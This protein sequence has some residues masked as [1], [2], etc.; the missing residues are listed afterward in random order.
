[1]GDVTGFLQANDAYFLFGL[2]ILS[3]L[4]LVSTIVLAG[5]VA[6]LSRRRS[7]KIE[8]GRLSD[9]VEHLENNANAISEIQARLED[10]R[11][12]MCEQ[13]KA[14]ECCLQKVGIV[15]FNAFNDV[16]GEQSFAVVLLDSQANGIALSGLYGRQD[17]RVYAKAIFKGQGE[18]PLS[19][20]E[21]QALAKA[22]S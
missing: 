11:A 13:G 2:C 5:K 6:R 22:L 9:I 12:A 17:S 1:M 20:E 4:L 8:E 18:R 10:T 7:I 16:G 14:L 21:Q 3:L 15:R 19:D